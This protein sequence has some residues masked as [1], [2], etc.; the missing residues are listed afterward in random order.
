M[1]PVVEGSE[2]RLLEKLLERCEELRLV[3]LLGGMLYKDEED[4]PKATVIW[5]AMSLAA[6]LFGSVWH[7]DWK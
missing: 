4:C 7:I 3:S 5:I 6:V 1:R 2:K